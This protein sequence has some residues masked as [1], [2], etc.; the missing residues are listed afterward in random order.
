MAKLFF[1]AGISRKCPNS[2]RLKISRGGDRFTH[3]CD[4]V[5]LLQLRSSE[6]VTTWT[7]GVGWGFGRLELAIGS[8][9]GIKGKGSRLT[10]DPLIRK[11]K[12]LNK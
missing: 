1:C 4:D 5:H 2:R 6:R 12:N 9:T 8:F 7:S 3:Y 10:F 11:Q